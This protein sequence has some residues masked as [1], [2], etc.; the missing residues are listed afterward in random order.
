MMNRKKIFTDSSL[1]I[2][3]LNP[4]FE[5]CSR[6]AIILA[7]SNSQHLHVTSLLLL[8]NLNKRKLILKYEAS[9][10][11]TM[12]II[13]K[14]IS[15]SIWLTRSHE[16]YIRSFHKIPWHFSQT[17]QILPLLLR[18]KARQM[19]LYGCTG[20]EFCFLAMAWC[21]SHLW[22]IQIKYMF[23]YKEIHLHEN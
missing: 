22:K 7:T 2:C 8:G 1:V 11:T 20:P 16:T 6:K 9:D 14:C 21:W 12:L 18:C 4:R 17:E 5:S 10:L 13:I 19:S 3:K 23:Y 15:H